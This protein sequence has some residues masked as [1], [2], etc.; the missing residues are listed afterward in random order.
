MKKAPTRY[1]IQDS[2]KKFQSEDMLGDYK[3]F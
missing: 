3:F 1:N 2:F